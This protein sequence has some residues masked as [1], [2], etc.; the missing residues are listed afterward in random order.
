M[1]SSE[2]ERRLRLACDVGREAGALARRL[3]LGRDAGTFELKG[4]Q[5]YLTEADGQV[6]RLIKERIAAA[7]PHDSVLGEEGG[8]DIG[9]RT[10]VID[11]IDGT[12]N[13]ARGIA[14]FC[15]SIGYVE[16]GCK[17][18]GVISSPVEDEFYV[19]SLGGG[20]TLNGKPIKV[21]AIDDMRSATIEL[22]WSMRRPMADYIAMVQ[23]VTS[24]GAGFMRC[25]SGALALAAVAAGR[26]DGYA[27]L[28][29]NS[30]D[31]M[32]ALLMVE[33]AGGWANDFLANNGM[34]NGNPV[35]ACT[36]ALRAAL[37]GATGI[38]A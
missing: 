37:I 2:I 12:A 20:V 6:E 1:P 28:H 23:R 3:F 35:L 10:W 22:G 30:W 14:H 9:E 32:A 33:E 29:I 7:F 38:A 4:H 17:T 15:V 18:I 31:T 21:S 27:E 26:I 8:G 13:F 34:A 16:A 36:P 5:D 25:G 19:A 11:P 24:T